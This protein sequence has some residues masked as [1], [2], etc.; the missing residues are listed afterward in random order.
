MKK[1]ALLAAAATM[2]LAGCSSGPEAEWIVPLELGD[3]YTTTNVLSIAEAN[4]A[5]VVPVSNTVYA[6]NA[7]SNELAWTVTLGEEVSQCLPAGSNVL[8]ATGLHTTVALDR[9][10]NSAEHVGLAVEYSG[11]AGVY[12]AQAYEDRVELIKADPDASIDDIASGETVAVYDGRYANLPEGTRI[13]LGEDG[14]YPAQIQELVDAGVLRHN[15]AWLNP[16]AIAQLGQPLADGHVIIDG[17]AVQL[18]SVDPT[19][20]TIFDLHGTETEEITVETSLHMSVN[21]EWTQADMSEIVNEV[22]GLGTSHAFVFSDGEVVGFERIFSDSVAPAFANI[23]GFELSTGEKLGF[24]PI[25]PESQGLWVV[26]YPYV[27]VFGHGPDGEVA[28]TFD[29]ATGDRVI[30]GAKCQWTDGSTYCFTPDRLE[31]ITAF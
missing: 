19:T 9:E 29:V 6:F 21:P 16:P 15:S 14:S 10:G 31:K 27:S 20:V 4:G 26:D 30:E 17:G 28:A 24:D 5:V 2:A 18:T 12:V 11:P 7:A 23:E 3:S 8:C 13:E 1:F 25:S 22:A